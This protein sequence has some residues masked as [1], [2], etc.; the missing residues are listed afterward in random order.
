[1]NTT[2]IVKLNKLEREVEELKSLVFS[3]VP[4]DQEGEYKDSFIV[5]MKKIASQKPAFVYKGK[6]SLRSV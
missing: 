6:G 1:M 4:I 2:Q 5:R 3:I